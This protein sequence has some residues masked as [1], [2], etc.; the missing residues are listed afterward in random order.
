MIKLA[1]GRPWRC[2]DYANGNTAREPRSKLLEQP[3]W[4]GPSYPVH[5]ALS[6]N[7]VCYLLDRPSILFHRGNACY[8][9]FSNNIE[10]NRGTCCYGANARQSAPNACELTHIFDDRLGSCKQVRCILKNC[11]V[12]PTGDQV[13]NCS[14]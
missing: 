14:K 3:R 6:W 8:L 10:K 1:C 13:L 9:Q 5:Y 12:F 4:D 7:V 11:S 2:W